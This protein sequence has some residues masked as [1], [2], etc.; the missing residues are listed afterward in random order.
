MGFARHDAVK[1]QWIP[2]IN[3]CSE[4]N[5]V[6]LKMS[7]PFFIDT[8]AEDKLNIYIYESGDHSA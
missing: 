7:I 6:F 4:H 8:R 2:S 5:S 1:K 3:F